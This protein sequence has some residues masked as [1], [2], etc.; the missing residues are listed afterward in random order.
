MCWPQWM[1]KGTLVQVFLVASA[2]EFY[3]YAPLFG[4]VLT[5][6]KAF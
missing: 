2:E 5:T 6:L 4:R 1:K 3:H